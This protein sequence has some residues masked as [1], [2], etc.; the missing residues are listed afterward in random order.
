M[1]AAPSDPSCYHCGL[2]VPPGADYQV[3]IFGEPR[4]MCCPGCQT[5]A[6]AI[7]DNNLTSYYQQRTSAPRTPQE[8]VPDALRQL[9][10]YDREEVQRSFVQ[11]QEG[12]IREASLILEGIVCAACIWLSEQHVQSLPGVLDFRINYS[13]HRARL[14]WDVSRIQLSEVLEAIAAIGYVAHPFDPGRQE[15]LYKKERTKALRRL[16]VAGLGMMQ[17]MTLATSMYLGVGE[18]MDPTMRSFM[19]WISLIITVPV[20]FYSAQTFFLSAWRDLKRRKL[21]MDVPVSIAIGGAFLASVWATVMNTGEVYFDSVNMF[22]FF[23][24]TGRFLEM[25]AR[26]RAGQAMESLVRLLPKLAIRLDADGQEQ[27]IAITDVRPGDRLRIRPGDSVP[28]DGVVLEGRSSLDESLLTGESLPQLRGVG[29]SLIGGTVNVEGPL[30]M[31]VDKVGEDTVLSSIIRLLDRAQTE[32]PQIAHIADKVAAWFVGAMLLLAISVYAYWSMHTPEHAF[33]IVL[34]VLV[35]TCPCALSLATPTAITVATGRMSRSGLLTTRGP[36]LEALAQATDV[37]FDKTG[38]LTHGQLQ[39]VASYSLTEHGE[40]ELLRLAAALEQGSEHP[41][42]RAVQQ[43][44]AA[45]SQEAALPSVQN[46]EASP[47]FGIRGE[48]EGQALRLGRQEYIGANINSLP[49]LNPGE[50]RIWLADE[51]QVLGAFVFTD[52]LRKEAKYAIEQLRAAGLTPHLFSG[53]GPSA[54]R[55]VAQELGIEDAQARMRPDDKLAAVR[56]LE[57]EGRRVMMVGDGVNDAPVLAGSDVSVAMGKATQ[58]AQASADLV[59]FSEHLPHLAE[60]VHLARRTFR[61]IRQNFAWAIGYNLIAIPF[62]A[63]G[64]IAPWMA[65]I[66]MSLSSLVVVLNALRLGR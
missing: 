18:D 41:I 15:E 36:A 52:A 27:E 66:G 29:D 12:D 26:H 55:A 45:Q 4:A 9:K 21:G 3:V 54:V 1:S 25:G 51:T 37:V 39:W 57:T 34:S 56:A 61:I 40:T 35:V 53:D 33:W 50:T 19:R 13:T 62:A 20:V 49:P 42:A 10:L 6:Q 32:K 2:P 7:V 47:G 24:L 58:I 65:A 46:L 59:L 22:T 11:V 16:V 17:A 63:A 8:L 14:R 48:V 44:Y 28:C 43:A 30:V 5:V 64:F 38:T 23:L 31:R 60:G